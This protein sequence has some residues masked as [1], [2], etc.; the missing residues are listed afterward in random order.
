VLLLVL[1]FILQHLLVPPHLP[2]ALLP[3]QAVILQHPQASLHPPAL[4]LQVQAVIPLHLPVPLL[5]LLP[6][7]I[8]LL[9]VVPLTLA[10]LPLLLLTPNNPP[11]FHVLQAPSCLEHKSF[12]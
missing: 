12:D 10:V 7:A 4:P 9:P 2:E 5:Q 3:V 8:L 11:F 1:V 6:A